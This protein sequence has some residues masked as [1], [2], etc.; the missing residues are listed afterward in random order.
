MAYDSSKLSTITSGYKEYTINATET[1]SV[2]LGA[3]YFSGVTAGTII[4]TTDGVEGALPYPASGFFLVI[5]AAGTATVLGGATATPN[6]EVVTATNV[7]TASENGKTFYLNSATEFVSTLPAPALGLK[8]TFIVS[9]APSGAS[10][11]IVTTSSA[12]IIKGQIYSSDLNAASDADFETS[13]GD[14]ISFV[15]SKS[16]AG[17]CVT[18]ESDGTNWFARGFC[19]VFDAITITTA[20]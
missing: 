9:A 8:Y 17:D 1:L 18:V 4:R 16:V 13:G 19:S 5:D 6:A 11:T 3:A 7:I 12:N 15:D 20:S 10:Y 14:T 2:L